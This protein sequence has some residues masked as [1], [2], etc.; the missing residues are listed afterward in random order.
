MIDNESS[1][2]F[3]R[4]NILKNPSLR[5]YYEDIYS[6]IKRNLDPNLTVLE[7]GSGTG[8]SRVFMPNFDLVC[9]DFLD[10]IDFGVIANINMNETPFDDLSF[11]QILLVDSLHHSSHPNL[12]LT[13]CLRLLRPNGKIVIVEPF[14]SYFSFMIYRW[15]HHEDTSWSA[16]LDQLAKTDGAAHLGNQGI[17]K[18]FIKHYSKYENQN[19][20]HPVEGEQFRFTIDVEYFNFLSFFATGGSFKPISTPRGLIKLL[21][22]W[23]R[24]IPQFLLRLISSRCLISVKRIN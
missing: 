18:A 24:R 22:D 11:D 17:S 4:Q 13:E 7:L 5:L 2:I 12:T 1:L 21:L 15:F 3:Q 20:N 23:E 16:G 19:L 14:V 6:R 9:T 10:F 8:I